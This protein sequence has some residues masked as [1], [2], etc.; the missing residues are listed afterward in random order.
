MK[1][2]ILNKGELFYSSFAKVF[3]SVKELGEKYNWLIS[4]AE[5]YPRD[6]KYRNKLNG[7][8]FWMTGE[9]I[10][11]M[12][13]QEDFQWVWGVMSGFDKSIALEDI[14]KSKLPYAEGYM[15]FWEKP[16]SIQHTLADIEIVAW[17]SRCSLFICK[18]APLIEKIKD[19]YPFSKDLEEYNKA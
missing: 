18:S 16:L 8:Y 19:V 17:D 13:R 4:G 10:V 14:L 5:C 9:E 2:L 7:T 1:G 12:F 3:I 6:I 15:G 11:D